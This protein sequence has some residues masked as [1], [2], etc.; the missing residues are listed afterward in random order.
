MKTLFRFK[1]KNNKIYQVTDPGPKVYEFESYYSFSENTLQDM[2]NGGL[3]ETC[4]SGDHP[5]IY[6][7]LSV[8]KKTIAAFMT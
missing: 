2:I 8:N 4:L 1:V 7:D 5:E 3:C 6:S